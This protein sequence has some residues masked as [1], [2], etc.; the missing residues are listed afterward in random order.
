VGEDH[1]R[2]R[3]KHAKLMILEFLVNVSARVFTKTLIDTSINIASFFHVSLFTTR[4]GRP[5][6]LQRPA[7]IEV[8]GD[9]HIVSKLAYYDM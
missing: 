1:F 3:E 8:R 9:A 5:I 7:S 4:A 2:R 6:L